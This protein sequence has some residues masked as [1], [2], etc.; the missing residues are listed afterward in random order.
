MALRGLHGVDGDKITL[1]LMQSPSGGPETY[2]LGH[3]AKPG[4]IDFFLSHSW[5][6]DPVQK[7]AA[8]QNVI[9]DFKK[10]HGRTPSFWLDKVRNS[11]GTATHTHVP[12]TRFA[13]F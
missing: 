12:T 7:F 1:E 11:Y 8:I 3:K 5:H 2:A 13:C 9:A 6:D 4:E 10:Q